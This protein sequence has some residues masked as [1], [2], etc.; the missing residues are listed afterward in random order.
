M[1]LIA[2]V[3]KKTLVQIDS[4]TLDASFSET[5]SADIEVTEHPVESGVNITDH[6]RPKPDKL[7]I[8]GFFSNDALPDSSAPLVE[9]SAQLGDGSSISYLSRSSTQADRSGEAYAGLL[10]IRDA[11]KLITIVT[12]LRTYEN[13]LMTSLEVP[14]DPK[15]GQA[16]RF[17]AQFTEVKLVTNETAA[18]TPAAKAKELGKKPPEATP[19]E[20]N[21]SALSWVDDKAGKGISKGINSFLDSVTK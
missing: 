14:R 10:A 3:F 17:S 15:S 7:K 21:Q 9:Q 19:T 8:E 18:F 20:T 6:A 1:A 12:A 5:H 11:G 2:L 13:M 16:L 4:L